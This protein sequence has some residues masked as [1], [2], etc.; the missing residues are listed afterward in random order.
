MINDAK[1]IMVVIVS[2]LELL[3]TR[4]VRYVDVKLDMFGTLIKPRV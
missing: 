2:G 4:V 1:M 3:M